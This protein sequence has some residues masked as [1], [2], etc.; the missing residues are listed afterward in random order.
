[1]VEDWTFRFLLC[2]SRP[3]AFIHHHGPVFSNQCAPRVI[4]ILTK[5][6]LA[7][8]VTLP[9]SGISCLR[10]GVAHVNVFSQCSL[11][12]FR[13]LSSIPGGGPTWCWRIMARVSQLAHLG[14][15]AFTCG[16]GLIGW[17]NPLSPPCI[18]R[19]FVLHGLSS[20]SKFLAVFLAV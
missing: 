1:M 19:K 18:P 6:D 17:I 11:L 13:L 9:P 15:V 16:T 4:G 7:V 8:T 14:A 3:C 20:K 5:H 12:V 2:G 10:T